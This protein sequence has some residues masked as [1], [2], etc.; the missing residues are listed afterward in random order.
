MQRILQNATGLDTKLISIYEKK[1][2]FSH[3]EITSI[4]IKYSLTLV[5]K[6]WTFYT[7]IYLMHCTKQRKHN[8][9]KLAAESK[10]AT[11]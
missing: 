8:K 7:T 11:L 6:V 2:T 10:E 9:T 5:K 1:S 4:G 3:F